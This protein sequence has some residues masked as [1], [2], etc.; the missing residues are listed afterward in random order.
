M[1]GDL[2]MRAVDHLHLTFHEAFERRIAESAREGEDMLNAFFLERPCKQSAPSDF[3]DLTHRLAFS[4]PCMMM[5][6]GK[7]VSADIGYLPMTSQPHY[8][9]RLGADKVQ[10]IGQTPRSTRTQPI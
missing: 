5:R 10:N 1:A 6:A 3:S 8:G 7:V 4:I 9:A 2:L